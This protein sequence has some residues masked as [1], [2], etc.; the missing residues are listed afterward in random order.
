VLGPLWTL[1]PSNKAILPILWM[2]YPNHPYLLDTQ[3][4]LTEALAAAGHVAKPIVG[5]CGQNIASYDRNSALVTSSSG[6]FA[7][8]DMIYQQLF[9]LPKIGGMNVQLWSFSVGGTFSGACVRVDP[10]AIITT[11]SDI[12]PLRVV[13]DAAL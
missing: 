3:F 6:R 8:R 1:I 9:P 12:L 2:L 4:E 5:R 13:P 7:E 10:S 11:K